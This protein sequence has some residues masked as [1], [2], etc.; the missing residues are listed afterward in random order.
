MPAFQA[1][2]EYLGFFHPGLALARCTPG[3]HMPGLRP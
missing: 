2:I 3:Y 1:S